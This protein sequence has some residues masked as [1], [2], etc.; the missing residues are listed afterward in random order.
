[1]SEKT[2]SRY[3][4]FKGLKQV[5]VVPHGEKLKKARGLAL[6]DIL[7]SSAGREGQGRHDL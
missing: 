7:P 4:P 2:I 1:M 5:Y 3:C 6:I